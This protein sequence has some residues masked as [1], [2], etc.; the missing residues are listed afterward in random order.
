MLKHLYIECQRISRQMGNKNVPFWKTKTL[1]EMT[2]DEWE[3]LCDGCGL[4][5]LHTL[6]DAQTEKIHHT[7]VSCR[8]LDIERCRCIV[9][10]D[11]YV[12]PSYCKKITPENVLQLNWLPDTCAYRYVA[13]GRGLE[14]W[15]PLVSGDP[16]TV[17]QEGISA[18]NKAVSEQH[19]HPDDM[20]EFIICREDDD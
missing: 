4:C 15:H 1:E 18:H 20:E 3:S 7:Y 10:K 13:Q 12:A 11:P 16:D 14:R 2:R 5:C 17:H 8:Y 6:Q 19:V 9:Y